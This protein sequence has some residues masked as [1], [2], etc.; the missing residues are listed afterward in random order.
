MSNTT[1]YLITNINGKINKIS[2]CSFS[3]VLD[4]NPNKALYLQKFPPMNGTKIPDF[5]TNSLPSE[6][7]FDKIDKESFLAFWNDDNSYQANGSWKGGKWG[8]SNLMTTDTSWMFD[9]FIG[10]S[11]SI[12]LVK[13]GIIKFNGG[14]EFNEAMTILPNTEENVWSCN[15]DWNG[16]TYGVYLT[17]NI[18]P[19]YANDVIFI[20]KNL[21]GN[22]YIK[23]LTR[24]NNENVD[25]PLRM[26]PGAGEHMEPGT[27]VKV[28]DGI[29][30]AVNEEIGIDHSTLTKCYLLDLGIYNSKGRDP[31]YWEYSTLI[32]G[33]IINFG[34]KRG[35]TT[36][37]YILYLVSD[38]NNEPKE[39]TPEDTQEVGFKWWAKLDTVLAIYPND[40]WMILDHQKFIPD[41]ISKIAEFDMK[42]KESINEHLFN[43]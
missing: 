3:I 27:D 33:K 38:S 14:K 40:K 1:N 37:G 12:K 24:G 30:R 29:L 42:S 36:N 21:T 34:M 13:Q 19:Q 31:R 22:K 26:M 41:A 17:D 15:V 8:K 20:W 4:S 10:D 35:S 11:I 18:M 43:I 5:E 7:E 25:M 39:I 32:N 28:K 23:L 6:I 9:S 2:Y 16:K